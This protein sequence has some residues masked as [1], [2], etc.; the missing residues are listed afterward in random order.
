MSQSRSILHLQSQC[1]TLLSAVRGAAGLETGSVS[2]GHSLSSSALP[3]S[4]WLPGPCG[5][6]RSSPTGLRANRF[7]LVHAPNSIRVE[8]TSYILIF[9]KS[10]TEN[11][12]SLVVFGAWI[13]DFQCG[14]CPH[15]LWFLYRPDVWFSD[16]V[17]ISKPFLGRLS[18]YKQLKWTRNSV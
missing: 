15:A 2:P 6:S 9:G 11:P 17:S 8:K 12:G 14:H 5:G 7:S 18:A 16:F 4:S 1:A 3:G 10:I 13:R